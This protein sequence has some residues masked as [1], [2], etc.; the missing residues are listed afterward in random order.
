M[1][2]TNQKPLF[3]HVESGVINIHHIS[4]ITK[5]K[6]LDPHDG[7]YITKTCISMI[8]GKEFYVNL[9]IEDIMSSIQELKENNVSCT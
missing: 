5:T 1:I 3:I 9:E 2:M 6:T 8:N 4:S 7:I